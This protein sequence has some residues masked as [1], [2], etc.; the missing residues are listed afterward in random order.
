[1]TP[2]S[3]EEVRGPVR[4]LRVESGAEWDSSA[5]AWLPPRRRSII[6]FRSEDGRFAVTAPAGTS[7]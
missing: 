4:T 1:M 2:V 6:S 7:P 3:D 5:A